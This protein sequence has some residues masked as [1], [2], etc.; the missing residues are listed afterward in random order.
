MTPRSAPS[1]RSCRSGASAAGEPEVGPVGVRLTLPRG[2]A[3]E[4]R[5]ASVVLSRLLAGPEAGEG[6]RVRRADCHSV[7]VCHIGRIGDCSGCAPG[8]AAPASGD[9]GGPSRR[10]PHRIWHASP[11]RVVS[12]WCLRCLC[13]RESA[14]H[15]ARG[16]VAPRGI[17]RGS[18][19]RHPRAGAVRPALLVAGGVVAG[20][21][22][23][24]AHRLVRRG[25]R[26][27]VA[28][29]PLPPR[30]LDARARRRR[31]RRRVRG[32]APCSA[33]A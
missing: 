33:V 26:Q 12:S 2:A 21:G 15:P 32:R 30:S 4:A 9:R 16:R 31:S 17:D 6:S 7:G 24:P 19:H 22:R 25:A 27:L 14:R 29:D 18:R 11:S 28:A 5:M 1:A 20:G 10:Q 23:E 13:A 3:R 8:R